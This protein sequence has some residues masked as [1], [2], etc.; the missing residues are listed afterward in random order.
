[1]KKD[2]AQLEMFKQIWRDRP[3]YSEVSGEPLIGF[4]LAYFSH[5]LSKGAHPK[6]K[7]NPE[8]ILLKTVQEHNEW[9]FGDRERLRKESKWKKV[10]ELQERLKNER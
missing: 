2:N 3:H 5:I 6:H 1:M 7:L 10:F 8:N 4:N 9:E